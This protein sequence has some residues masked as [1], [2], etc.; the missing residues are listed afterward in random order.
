MSALTFEQIR[1]L[2]LMVS[3]TVPDQLNCDACGDLLGELAEAENRGEE[4]SETLKAAEVHFSQCPC[5]AYEYAT[6]REA[7]HEADAAQNGD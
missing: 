1:K 6:L 2:L 4:L 5:C 7:I 3:K